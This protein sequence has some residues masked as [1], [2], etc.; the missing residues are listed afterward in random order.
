MSNQLS[1][2]EQILFSTKR[3][4][5]TIDGVG[6]GTSGTGFFFSFGSKEKIVPSIVT[7]KHVIQ[8][9]NGCWLY[10]H[11]A[12]NGKPTSTVKKV[13]VNFKECPVFL[14]PDPEV[15]LCAIMMAPILNE[16]GDQ[17]YYAGIGFTNIPENWSQF[18]ALEEILMVGCPRGIMDESNKLPIFRRGNTATPLFSNYNGKPEFMVDMACF[19]GSSGSPL[20]ILNEGS[21]KVDNGIALG[22]RFFF[23]GVLY[24]GPVIQNDGT[25]EFTKNPKLSVGTMMH[26][27]NVIKADELRK[28]EKL[29]PM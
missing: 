5:P 4:E 10:L 6:T 15:D 17:V 28:I 12:E 21:Y 9:S 2:S 8:G 1:I 25:I 27:G 18:D 16:L 29:I 13:L 22:T 23:I 14:H 20:F 24:S 3:L 11:G 19:P 7:N 26:L